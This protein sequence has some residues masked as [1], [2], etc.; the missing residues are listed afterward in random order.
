MASGRFYMNIIEFAHNIHNDQ[1]YGDKPYTHHLY[2]VERVLQ[3]AGKVDVDDI[4]IA[5]CHDVIEECSDEER[6]TVIDFFRQNLSNH[7]FSVVWALSGFGDNRK[8]RNMDA[9]SKIAAYPSS[10]DYKVADRICNQESAKLWNVKLYDMYVGE[11][12]EFASNV[13]SLATNQ[14]LIDRFWA[15]LEENFEFEKLGDDFGM[16]IPD[17]EE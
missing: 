17:F 6:A 14:Y 16:R 9:Y 1:K 10:A 15:S 2:A 8:L 5:H 11:S 12:A 13:V 7:A 4:H 3:D